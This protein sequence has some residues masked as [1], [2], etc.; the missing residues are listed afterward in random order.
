[1]FRRKADKTLE[2]IKNKRAIKSRNQF[3]FNKA[4]NASLKLIFVEMYQKQRTVMTIFS[5]NFRDLI[6]LDSFFLIAPSDV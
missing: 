3:A 1:M 6:I 2:S 5:I 4:F